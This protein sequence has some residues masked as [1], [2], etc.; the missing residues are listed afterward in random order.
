M[1]KRIPPVYLEPVKQ[2]AVPI[3]QLVRVTGPVVHMVNYTFI[4]GY[5]PSTM[6]A[7][8]RTT[9]IFQ[10]CSSIKL[11]AVVYDYTAPNNDHCK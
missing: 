11:A 7:S 6:N 3:I 4:E 8:C 2:L 5:I 10:R 9:G 1:R